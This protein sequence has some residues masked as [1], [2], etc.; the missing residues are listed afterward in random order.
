MYSRRKVLHNVRHIIFDLDGTLVRI[1]VPWKQVYNRLSALLGYRVTSIVALYAKIWKSNEYDV[2]SRIVEEYELSAIDNIEVL[3]NSPEIIKRLSEKYTLS[4]VTLQSTK[5]MD[6]IL[7]KLGISSFFRAKISRNVSPIR[8]EQILKAVNITNIPT[9]NTLVVG[10]LLNDVES[11]IKAGCLAILIVR[12][13]VQK[14][15]I[16]GKYMII[17]NLEE[18]YSLLY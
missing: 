13:G 7:N 3:D 9:R 5:V 15:K 11:A 17:R 16:N 6:K 4:L 18:L 14:E 10:D 12:E 8:Y 2:V 1:P